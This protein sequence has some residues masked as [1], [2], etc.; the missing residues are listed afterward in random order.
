MKL[1]SRIN[2]FEKHRERLGKNL[3]ELDSEKIKEE[4][5]RV[6]PIAREYNESNGVYSQYVFENF[7]K[8]IDEVDIQKI[9]NDNAEREGIIDPTPTPI[10]EAQP[11][12]EPEQSNS[13]SV[14]Q[15][16]QRTHTPYQIGDAQNTVKKFKYY[17][18][19]E[20]CIFFILAKPKFVLSDKG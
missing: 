5:E 20:F 10:S 3:E 9:I 17:I 16:I 2:V 7:G 6:Y 15:D 12:Y 13:N 8:G 19:L 4:P 11:I 18:N 1:E 14:E